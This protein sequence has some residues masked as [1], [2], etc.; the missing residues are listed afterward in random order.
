MKIAETMR[1]EFKERV[2][3]DMTGEIDQE[4]SWA[5]LNGLVISYLKANKI[6]SKDREEKLNVAIKKVIMSLPKYRFACDVY[7][8]EEKAEEYFALCPQEI[9][10]GLSYEDICEEKVMEI[11][12]KVVE[13]SAENGVVEGGKM[14]IPDRGISK[15]SMEEFKS[16][17]NA[18][19][20]NIVAIKNSEIE[21]AYSIALDYFLNFAK[22][23]VNDEVRFHSANSQYIVKFYSNI[24]HSKQKEGAEEEDGTENF[25]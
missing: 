25:A 5:I 4:A 11:A 8:T 21:S 6:Y 17:K 22:K 23:A 3:D 24:L 20:G 14:S 10:A 19:M 16:A 9:V 1:E 7:D 12:D 18:V 15:A 13:F 2:L